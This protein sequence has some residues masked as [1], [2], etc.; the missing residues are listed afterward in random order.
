MMLRIIQNVNG[1][2]G[3]HNME[4]NIYWSRWAKR[5]GFWPMPNISISGCG[6]ERNG[7]QRHKRPTTTNYY[8]RKYTKNA[9]SGTLRVL[10][11]VLYPYK[12]CVFLCVCVYL[13]A[14]EFIKPFVESRQYHC[15][16]AFPLAPSILSSAWYF[17]FYL[18]NTPRKKNSHTQCMNILLIQ[19]TAECKT[20]P[21]RGQRQDT[22]IYLG[23]GWHIWGK[24]RRNRRFITIYCNIKRQGFDEDI[25]N[26]ISPSLRLD[27]FF[28]AALYRSLGI[29]VS[30]HVIS[31]DGSV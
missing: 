11:Y 2:N 25:S 22:R 7:D 12:V 30:V 18:P 19:R 8:R 4:Y 17:I 5:K 1:T 26:I 29:F 23:D 10:S 14:S 9:Y 28:A 3:I 20:L 6:E 13:S 15:S 21:R 27:F 24:R 16:A 31:F